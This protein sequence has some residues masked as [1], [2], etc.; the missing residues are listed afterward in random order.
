MSK[1]ETNFTIGIPADKPH[2][3]KAFIL[4][5]LIESEL[6]KVKLQKNR[7][8][9][10]KNDKADLSTLFADIH[11]LLI[12]LG[13][14][15]KLLKEVRKLFNTDKTYSGICDMY[16]SKLDAIG[17]VRNHL[18][19]ILDGRLDGVGNKGKPLVEPNMFGNL[20]GDEYNFGGDKVNL[21]DTY[22]MIDEL[23][24]D[25]RSWNKTAQINPFWRA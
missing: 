13:N 9:A 7:I 6:K 12:T 17:I 25:L 11:F 18:E 14:L 23:E 4:S 21:K 22:K 20:F 3:R 16:L 19:H 1:N 2:Y 24:N 8:E 5:F 10:E 15:R